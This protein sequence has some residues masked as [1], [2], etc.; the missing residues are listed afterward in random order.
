[1][2]D[3]LARAPGATVR[4]LP[5]ILERGLFDAALEG[6]LR[7]RAAVEQR[8]SEAHRKALVKR[9]ATLELVR[10][11]LEEQR[12]TAL[13]Y[14]TL[15]RKPAAIGEPQRGSNCQL[16]ATTGLPAL[17]LP[18]GFTD[19]GLPV[20]LELLGPAWSDADLLSLAYALERAAPQRRAP[21]ST[22]PLAGGKAPGPL[23]FEVVAKGE[24]PGV[25]KTRFTFD[26]TTGVLSYTAAVAGMPTSEVLAASLHRGEETKDGAALA[27]LLAAG[28]SGGS[29]S[30]T[31]QPRDRGE[32][33]AGR[34]CVRLYTRANPLGA[35]RAQ[36]RL[37]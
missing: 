18:A 21:P 33:R 37:P 8:D 32:L 19:D 20:G 7:R 11:T 29:G 10:A 34:L 17:S 13:A 4:S 16:S 3:Y 28:E 35:A 23:V 14:P 9:R 2:A 24:A 5:E 12:L 36:L 25:L 15:R 6:P 26:E 27:R 1:M 22:P 31:L 30:V